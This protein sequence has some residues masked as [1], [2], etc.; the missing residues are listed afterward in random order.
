MLN[1]K[2]GPLIGCESSL[3]DLRLLNQCT[4]D[5]TEGEAGQHKVSPHRR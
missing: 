3:T 4:E 1:G 2:R 5:R